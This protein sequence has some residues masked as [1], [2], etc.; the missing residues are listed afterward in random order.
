MLNGKTLNKVRIGVDLG[1]TDI[2]FGVVD[3]DNN[4]VDKWIVPTPKGCDNITDTI[5]GKCREIM[6]SYDV[7]SVG[8]GTPGLIRHNR[9]TAFNLDLNAFPLSDVL[10]EKIGTPVKMS[11]D[12]NCAALGESAEGA[13]K[14]ASNCIVITL[15]TGV[16]GGII[17]D[18]RIYEGAGSGGELGHMCIQH[19]GIPC[20]C[21]QKGCYEKYASATALIR[22]ATEHAQANP[23]SILAKKYT[24]NGSKL[25]GLMIFDSEREGC[26]VAKKVIDIYADY[27]ACGINSY[28]FIFDPDMIVISGGI[29]NAGDLLLDP[30]RAKIPFDIPLKAAQ[31]KNDA[32]IIGASLL[33]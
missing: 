1:G 9:V 21:G 4:I 2:K 26:P 13:A 5:A 14:E 25:N 19:N 20:S 6:Q 27:V 17:I 24:A 23:D 33:N 31:L 11:N 3:S 22:Y 12:A 29:S 15:G 7:T 32:G 10:T 8:I 16:G 18:N 28:I 30:I